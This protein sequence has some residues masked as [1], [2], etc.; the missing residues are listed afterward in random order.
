MDAEKSK[1]V[2]DLKE[3]RKHV[4]VEIMGEVKFE[5]I[6]D[7]K[8]K[9]VG[10]IY[11]IGIGGVSILIEKELKPGISLRLDFDLEDG[12][13]SFVVLGSV[14]WQD[15]FAAGKGQLMEGWYRTGII[16]TDMD[17]ERIQRVFRFLYNHVNKSRV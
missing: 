15:K 1:H 3:K 8:I 9:D 12:M 4:R 7:P 2:S 10:L 14:V 16:F 6:H 13:G 17:K 11:D 5:A